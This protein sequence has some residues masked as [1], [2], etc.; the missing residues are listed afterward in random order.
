MG[1]KWKIGDWLDWNGSR[2]LV[3]DRYETAGA[4]RLD[5]IGCDR[6]TVTTRIAVCDVLKHL[7]DCTG[8]D[9]QPPKQIEPPEGYRLLTT[10]DTILATDQWWHWHE[11]WDE[12]DSQSRCIGQL[13]DVKAG[14]TPMCRK[15]EPQ[16]RPFR[17]GDEIKAIRDK[18]VRIVKPTSSAILAMRIDSYTH[19]LVFLANAVGYD[20]LEALEQL[21]FEDGTPFGVLINGQD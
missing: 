4:A 21:E 20:F 6:K 12:L 11:Y 8:W 15:I 3:I 5:I 10:A 13:W 17:N 18:W 19:D 16:Y 9:W 14:H 1:H 2:Y 7:P